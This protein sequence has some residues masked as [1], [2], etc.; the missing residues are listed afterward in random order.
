MSKAI[1]FQ[2]AKLVICFLIVKQT[3]ALLAADAPGNGVAIA[4]G[5]RGVWIVTK[6]MPDPN[7]AVARLLNNDPKYFGASLTFTRDAVSWD[8]S[9]TDGNGS[10]YNCNKP[11]YV[12]STDTPGFYAVTCDSDS[13]AFNATVKA[14]DR[15]T[16]IL[17]WYDGGILTLTRKSAGG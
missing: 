11:A 13:P 3:P 12:I 15:D 16:M 9:K 7:L 1:A 10:Y 8:S 6:V 2:A 14:I 17:N 4:G 5:L